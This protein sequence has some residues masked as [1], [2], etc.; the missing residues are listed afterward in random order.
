MKIRAFGVGVAVTGMLVAMSGIAHADHEM[1]VVAGK[2]GAAPSQ[3]C[4][5]AG[6]RQAALEAEDTAAPIQLLQTEKV[7]SAYVGSVNEV[8]AGMVLRDNGMITPY[9]AQLND[10]AHA[11]CTKPDAAPAVK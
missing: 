10:T 2:Q 1:V 6:L 4:A 8:E 9:V 11:L 3:I 5:D 7:A